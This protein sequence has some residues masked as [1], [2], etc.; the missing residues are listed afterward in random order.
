[1]VARS[2][3]NSRGWKVELQLALLWSSSSSHS[4]GLRAKRNAKTRSSLALPFLK[5]PPFISGS[6]NLR[7]MSTDVI[8]NLHSVGSTVSIPMTNDV[9]TGAVFYHHQQQQSAKKKAST[10]AVDLVN[11]NIEREAST[12]GTNNDDEEAAILDD[13]TEAPR[14][15]ATVLTTTCETS[16][17]S[18]GVPLAYPMPII[19]S[20]SSGSN[21][22]MEI[23]PNVCEQKRTGI[24]CMI[25]RLEDLVLASF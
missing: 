13:S 24:L 17:S 6:P 11:N 5:S 2:Y 9:E 20:L 7:S 8:R 3:D 14:R 21:D 1:V 22:E 18:V 10:V 12:T 16:V 25:V 23:V 4:T 19:S 15:T